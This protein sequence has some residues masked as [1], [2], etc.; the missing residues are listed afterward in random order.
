MSGSRRNFMKMFGFLVTGS[1][2][3]MSVPSVSTDDN[4]S[5]IDPFLPQK[6]FGYSQT[7]QLYDI[8]IDPKDVFFGS[9]AVIRVEYRGINPDSGEATLSGFV[10]SPLLEFHKDYRPDVPVSSGSATYCKSAHPVGC[11]YAY[12]DCRKIPYAYKTD[13]TFYPAGVDKLD[14][15]NNE[16]V[17]GHIGLWS[18]REGGEGDII[19]LSGYQTIKDVKPVLVNGLSRKVEIPVHETLLYREEL[20]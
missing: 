5:Q 11:Y 9:K 7:V 3:S 20:P 8:R 18:P 1:V 13:I 12:E 14:E 6:G 15:N 2:I 19:T 16:T 17:V 4:S 10:Q